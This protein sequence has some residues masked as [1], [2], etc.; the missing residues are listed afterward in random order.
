[1]PRSPCALPYRTSFIQHM[2]NQSQALLDKGGYL[3]VVMLL[4]HY[5]QGLH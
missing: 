4:L 1:M 5:C 2:Q 3:G